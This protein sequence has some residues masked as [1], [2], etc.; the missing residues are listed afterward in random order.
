M[1]VYIQLLT[2]TTDGGAK[3]LEDPET[4]FKVQDDIAVG[5]T[6]VLG[7]YG[8]LGAYDFVNIV[9]APDNDAIARFSLELGVRAG[10]HITTL[11]TVPIGDMEPIGPEDF[12]WIETEATGPI[13]V[14]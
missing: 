8:V 4:I 6:K 11:S 10:V 12:P 2:L 13:G 7:V 14:D 9:E 5:G 1:P 3:A